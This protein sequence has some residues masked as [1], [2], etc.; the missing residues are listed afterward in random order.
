METKKS[1][2]SYFKRF[3]LS[4]DPFGTPVAEQELKLA[5]DIF[6]KY[7]VPPQIGSSH[8]E[9]N[10]Q[11][12]RKAQHAFIFGFPGSGK[13]TLRLALEADCRTV[14]DGTLTISHNLGEDFK[15]SLSLEEHGVRLARE[16]ALDLI[17][18]VIEQFSPSKKFPSPEQI[19]GLQRQVQAGGNHLRRLIR[20][21]LEH[22]SDLGINNI[23]DINLSMYWHTV[24]KAPVRY[25]P[26]SKELFKLLV[27]VLPD[28]QS[29]PK[30]GWENFWD[31]LKTA[32]LLG[33]QRTLI[34]V[35]GVDTRE[36]SRQNMFE[37]ISPLLTFLPKVHDIDLFFKFFLPVGLESLVK[38][39]LRR[40]S[41]PL[42]LQS[43]FSI[44]NWDKRAL[45]QIL[46]QRFQSAGIRSNGL[47]ALAESGLNLDAKVIQASKG[48]P[49]QMLEI[50]HSLFRTHMLRNPDTPI[51]RRQDWVETIAKWKV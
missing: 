48:S 40:L 16:L 39:E 13:S 20:R 32:R 30:V 33:F 26:A 6:Y 31:G 49:R 21:L 5:G 38:K 34:L 10:L 22:E 28:P 23:S 11:A 45:Q 8:Q 9:L 14:L 3:G 25:V 18:Q 1:Q 36:S 43:Q 46:T 2:I 27:M 24:G 47:D 44:M 15:K 51:L 42:L 37:L 4:H 35:D 50:V 41:P 12:L 17:I 19:Q 29:T 7:F